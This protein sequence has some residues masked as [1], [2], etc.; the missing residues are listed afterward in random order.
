MLVAWRC[1]EMHCCS[2]AFGAVPLEKVVDF[3]EKMER[4]EVSE[5]VVTW[6]FLPFSMLTK[7]ALGGAADTTPRV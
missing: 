5:S 7:K 4:L 3:R 2:Q 1:A 6:P